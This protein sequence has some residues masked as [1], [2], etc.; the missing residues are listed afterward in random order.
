[1]LTDLINDQVLIGLAQAA[2]AIV[3]VL[4]VVTVCR[5]FNVDVLSET[6]ISLVRGLVQMVIV[7][8]LLAV[9]LKGNLL[10]GAV[11]LLGMVVA[12]AVT[13]SRRFK[14]LKYAFEV[15]LI[16]IGAGGGTAIAFMLLTKSLD[17]SIAVLVPVG[18][19]IIANSMNACAQAIERFRSDVYSHIGQ[20]EAALCLGATPSKSAAPYVQAAVYAS[21][22]PRLDMLKSLGLVWIPGVMAGMMVSGSSPLYAGIYQFMIVV[23]ILV[24]SGISGMGVVALMQRHA[25]SSTG[26]LLLRPARDDAIEA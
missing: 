23:M 15:S 8:L 5:R 25:F 13:A 21:L 24:A 4:I 7:G 20:I 16:S 22:L 10:V 18:S 2:A 11:I 9:F 26:Q 1:M 3:L 17:P 6:R 14:E 12:A 19:M